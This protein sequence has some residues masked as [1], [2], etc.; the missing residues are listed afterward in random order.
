MPRSRNPLS[1][2]TLLDIHLSA[3]LT[4]HKWDADPEP[5]IAELRREAG[6]RLDILA[7]AAGRWAGF[8]EKDEAAQALVAAVMQLDLPGLDEATVLGRDR[9]RQRPH[10]TPPAMH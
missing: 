5:V 9:A 2:E 8:T 10:G 4:R 7:A 1:A 3:I 6:D